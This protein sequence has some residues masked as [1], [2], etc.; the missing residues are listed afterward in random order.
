MRKLLIALTALICFATTTH[1]EIRFAPPAHKFSF[2]G[3]N[4]DPHRFNLVGESR[5][6][7]RRV[8]DKD[9]KQQTTGPIKQMQE[10]FSPLKVKD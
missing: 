2:E 1:G 3:P 7:H 5:G 4:V 8:V 6:I 9:F 10:R